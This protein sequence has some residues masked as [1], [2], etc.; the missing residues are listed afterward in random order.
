MT[1]FDGWPGDWTEPH[2]AEPYDGSEPYDACPLDHTDPYHDSGLA[3]DRPADD[4]APGHDAGGH[5]DLAAAA[6]QPD[7]A[8]AGG[9]PGADGGPAHGADD[10]PGHD[11]GSPRAEAFAGGPDADTH[12]AGTHLPGEHTDPATEAYPDG[13]PDADAHP[14]PYTPDHSGADP[15]PA[16]FAPPA[17]APD[18]PFPPQLDLDLAPDDGQPWTD[19]DLLGAEHDGGTAEALAPTD[20]PN[21]LLSDL[22]AVEGEHGPDGLASSDDPAIR[23]LAAYWSR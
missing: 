4:S 17:D 11:S 14:E 9:D 19:P 6:G 12:G 21:A 13:G 2:S 8:A 15:D 20:P 16:A 7:A 22:A 18:S 23:A 10:G 5:D 1:G 3:D